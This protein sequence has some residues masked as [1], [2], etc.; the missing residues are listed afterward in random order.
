MINKMN[1]NTKI[2]STQQR[3]IAYKVLI[4]DYHHNIGVCK[5]KYPFDFEKQLECYSN[6]GQH[7]KMSVLGIQYKYETCCDGE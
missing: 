4:E 6:L 7:I 2:T 5:N 3:Q 1:Q